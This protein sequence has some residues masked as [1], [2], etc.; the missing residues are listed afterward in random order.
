[1]VVCP[2]SRLDADALP[3]FFVIK[4]ALASLHEQPSNTNWHGWLQDSN[5]ASNNVTDFLDNP[6]E[7]LTKAG[8]NAKLPSNGG[9]NQDVCIPI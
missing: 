7:L 1:V 3:G 2:T 5:E 4:S 6:P 9:K 8:L